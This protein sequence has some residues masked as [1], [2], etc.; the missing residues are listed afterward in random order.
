MH[1]F[2][3]YVYI[4][5]R[6]RFTFY[7]HCQLFIFFFWISYHN[8]VIYCKNLYSIFKIYPVHSHIIVFFLSHLKN[9]KILNKTN[10]LNDFKNRCKI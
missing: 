3:V 7:D 2:F 6:I 4:Q 5:N 8:L 10:K 9:I 1:R